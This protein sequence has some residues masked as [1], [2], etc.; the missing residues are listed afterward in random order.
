MERA[1]PYKCD[2]REREREKAS[3]V[4]SLA[5]SKL[6]YACVVDD[7]GIIWDHRGDRIFVLERNRDI[8]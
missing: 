3:K 2:P 4:V 6:Y 1:R 8:T 7:S 5:F